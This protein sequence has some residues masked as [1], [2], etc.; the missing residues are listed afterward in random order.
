MI[1]LEK[2]LEENYEKWQNRKYLYEKSDG[3]FQAV[4]YGNFLDKSRVLADYLIGQGLWDKPVLIWGNNS[5][6]LMLADFAVLHYVG[7]SVC[8]SKEWKYQ[9][10]L[11]AMKLLDISCI[12]YGEEKEDI[13]SKIKEEMPTVM[14]I[15]MS[16]FSKIFEAEEMQEKS[17]SR[18]LH[19]REEALC[20]KIVFSSG[21]TANP[22]AVMLSKKN[23]FAGLNSLYKRCPFHE[24]DVDYL[25]LPLSHTYGGIYNFL[26]SLVFGFSI[27]L[28][29][30]IAN[31]GQEILEVN[32]TLFCGVPAIYRRFYEEYGSK[33]GMAFGSRIQYLFCG[34]ASFEEDI[35]R[36]YKD[37]GL[38]MM[39]A[40]ALSETASTFAIQYPNDSDTKS[41]GTIAEDI[42]VK[43]SNADAMGIGEIVVKGENVFMGYA[44]DKELTDSVFTEDGFF[45]TGDLG[46][47]EPDERNGGYK[48]YITGRMKKLL[49]GE[50][51]EKVEPTHIEKMICEKN[52]NINKALVYMQ[53]SKL[54]CH[55]YLLD[56]ENR[57]WEAFFDE[58]NQEL[59]KYE[60]I[61]DYDIVLDSVEKRLK[62]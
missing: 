44:N 1:D 23:M 30:G 46:Y 42:E 58:V 32:P 12:I 61:A 52:P 11:R 57:D 21:T 43:I 47:M 10:V 14:C 39:E 40:Y 13:V 16:S 59:P 26:Y 37:S 56:P 27:Y 36:V 2:V 35:R 22:K 49:I 34:G 8:V 24:G 25:F 3:V 7:I 4:T 41:V 29:S 48:L 50:N 60:R 28:C 31:M 51:G 62:Q 19:P 18:K 5:V 45:R 15:C 17:V 38:N 6:N 55:I 54:G 9:D 20:C 33:I 53:D